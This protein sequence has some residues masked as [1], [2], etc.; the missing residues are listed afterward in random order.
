VFNSGYPGVLFALVTPDFGAAL[1]LDDGPSVLFDPSDCDFSFF[2][3][4]LIGSEAVALQWDRHLAIAPAPQHHS[5][6]T[7]VFRTGFRP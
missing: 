5:I 2:H 7:V 3:D 4:G 1:K 6:A